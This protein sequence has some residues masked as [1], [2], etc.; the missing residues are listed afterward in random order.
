[1]PK[2]KALSGVDVVKIL[3]VFGF[4]V[5]SQK[6]S[7]AKLA[8]VRGETREILTVPTHKELDRGTLRAIFRQASRFIPESDLSQ[9]FYT[10]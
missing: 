2:L 7:H 6:G 3:S 10:E 5:V 8:R 9:H 1:M 4:S